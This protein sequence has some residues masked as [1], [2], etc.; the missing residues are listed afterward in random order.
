M[1][2]RALDRDIP[3]F[4]DQ[5]ITLTFNQLIASTRPGVPA[6]PAA[7]PGG[8]IPMWLGPPDI[9]QAVFVSVGA[10]IIVSTVLLGPVLQKNIEQKSTP[11]T[12]A[13]CYW[14]PPSSSP[15][16][17]CA[18]VPNPSEDGMPPPLQHYQSLPSNPR[19]GPPSP[20]LGQLQWLQSPPQNSPRYFAD[21]RSWGACSML[22]NVCGAGIKSGES[23]AHLSACR[24]LSGTRDARNPC[25]YSPFYSYM[26]P[27]S[28][29][30]QGVKTAWLPSLA[31]RQDRIRGGGSKGVFSVG[32]WESVFLMVGPTE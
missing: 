29:L 3:L 16:P 1:G 25:S 26:E 9:C 17:R 4:S 23:A 31:W 10:C 20:P 28:L 7:R 24:G 22:G 14:Q 18:P 21:G 30:H 6:I 15:W 32:D 5:P 12:K 11:S 19:Q 8:A 2:K 13:P 27:D